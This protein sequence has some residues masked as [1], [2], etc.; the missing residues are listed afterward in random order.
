[1][2]QHPEVIYMFYIYF[3][4]SE[5]HGGTGF[6]E[7]SLVVAEISLVVAGSPKNPSII[8]SSHHPTFLGTPPFSLDHNSLRCSWHS[9]LHK[10]SSIQSPVLMV[11]WVKQLLNEGLFLQ[12]LVICSVQYLQLL[13]PHWIVIN[14]KKHSSYCSPI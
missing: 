11:Q 3:T 6:S 5:I 8:P 14:K 2:V 9:I 4:T 10:R 12:I 7:F 13:P 1:M